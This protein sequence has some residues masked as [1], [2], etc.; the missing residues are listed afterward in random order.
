MARKT[1]P[2]LNMG[3]PESVLCSQNPLV[4]EFLHSAFGL[5]RNMVSPPSPRTWM[6][7]QVAG[8]VTVGPPREEEALWVKLEV[9]VAF[10]LQ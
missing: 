6:E 4:K 3:F 10:S 7:M 1:V 2:S 9:I 8:L 5:V